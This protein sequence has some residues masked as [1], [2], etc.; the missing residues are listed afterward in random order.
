MK[1]KIPQDHFT[2]YKKTYQYLQETLFIKKNSL[3]NLDFSK[4]ILNHYIKKGE[5]KKLQEK[6]INLVPPSSL[7]QNPLEEIQQNVYTCTK[8][9]LAKSRKQAVTFPHSQKSPVMVFNDIPSFYDQIQGEYFKDEVGKL[10]LKILHSLGLDIKQTYFTSVIKCASSIELG[11]QLEKVMICQE[12]LKKEIDLVKPK[13]IL[14]FGEDTYKFLFGKKDFLSIRGQKL[15]FQGVQIVFTYHPK[16]L[17]IDESLKKHCWD[18]LKPC[19][20]VIED[21]LE[22]K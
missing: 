8:C 2:L 1:I 17:I 22:K 11:N 4:E 3:A 16:D 12:H 5:K 6:V 21:F 14:A 10:H 13:L 20:K 9:F 19:K 15:T 18:D 7:P